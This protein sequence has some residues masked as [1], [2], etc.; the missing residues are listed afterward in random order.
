M[1]ENFLLISQLEN[2]VAGLREEDGRASDYNLCKV[3]S[4]LVMH[5][6]HAGYESRIKVEKAMR[7]PLGRA[8]L[9]APKNE[10]ADKQ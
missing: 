7:E 3:A 10:A 1:A 4:S 5:A 2:L 6:W 8:S 9:T